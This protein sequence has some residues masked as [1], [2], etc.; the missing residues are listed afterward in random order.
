MHAGLKL[1]EITMGEV[2]VQKEIANVKDSLPSSPKFDTK[3]FFDIKTFMSNLGE[4][5]ERRRGPGLAHL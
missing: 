2:I 3:I 4:V 1:L 5:P